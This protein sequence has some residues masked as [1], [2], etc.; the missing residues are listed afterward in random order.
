MRQC[1]SN[2]RSAK[3]VY[4]GPANRAFDLLGCPVTDGVL[5]MQAARWRLEHPETKQ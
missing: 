4:A 1:Y 3:F 2:V 5:L